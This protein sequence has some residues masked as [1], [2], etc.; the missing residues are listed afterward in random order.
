MLVTFAQRIWI[1]CLASLYWFSLSV[2]LTSL[3]Y[4][5][6]AVVILYRVTVQEQYCLEMSLSIIFDKLLKL[7]IFI[8]VIKNT[9]P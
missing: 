1:L 9:L 8:N 5:S 6:H 4:K 7:L 3:I 2:D